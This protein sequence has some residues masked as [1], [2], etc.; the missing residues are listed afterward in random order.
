M[1]IFASKKMTDK[2]NS[3]KKDNMVLALYHQGIESRD[4]G[5]IND[6]L[7]SF[8][9]C[10]K[11]A[12]A[13]PLG[14]YGM[15]DIYY[16]KQEYDSAFK[17][18]L[19]GVKAADLSVYP[20][21][22]YL[23]LGKILFDSANKL[24]MGID[25][26]EINNNLA[27]ELEHKSK[28][29]IYYK[30]YIQSEF[31]SFLGFGPNY[32]ENHHCIVYNSE[33]P[34]CGYRIL[35][36][37]IHL[38]LLIHNYELGISFPFTFGGKAY[39]SFF[40]RNIVKY[41]NQYSSMDFTLLNRMISK[42]FTILFAMLTTSILDMFIEY[43]IYSHME[44]VRPYQLLSLVNEV[45]RQNERVLKL[46]CEIPQE[47][48]DKFAI[49]SHLGHLNLQEQYGVYRNTE[50]QLL[51][52]SEKKAKEIFQMYKDTI[53]DKTCYFEHI[54]QVLDS[55]AERLEIKYFIE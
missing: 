18:S 28:M 39:Q 51:P 11:T 47:I 53:I 55:T 12:P 46:K 34:D 35:H 19:Q 17:Y 50:I 25:I 22:R 38:K 15:A 14:W 13:C 1:I 9:E 30:D 32:P 31:S 27:E 3:E 6:A 49:L 36:E 10:T 21:N 24:L 54:R 37:L 45:E 48:F 7:I 29:K 26:A 16:N 40:S 33:L 23:D 42:H 8:Y 41:Q 44:I 5:E 52:A 4:A 20:E 2:L 43:E